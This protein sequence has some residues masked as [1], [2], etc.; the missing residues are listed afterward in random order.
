M[1]RVGTVTVALGIIARTVPQINVLIVG[2]PIKMCL[3]LVVTAI[4]LGGCA[5]LLVRSFDWIM[6]ELDVVLQLMMG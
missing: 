6:G 5:A 3:G 1:L 4:A 2:F